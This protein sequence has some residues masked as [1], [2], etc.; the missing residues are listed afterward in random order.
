[1]KLKLIITFVFFLYSIS[2]FSN[3]NEAPEITNYFSENGQFML[4]VYPSHIPENYYK[5]KN[6]KPKKKQE[7]APEDTCIT[8]CHAILYKIA[9]ADTLKIWEKNLINQIAPVSVIVANDGQSVVT[10]DNWYSS[11]YG[12]NVMVIY[13]QKGELFKRY[14]LEDFSPFPIN[15][16]KMEI[17][18]ILWRCGQKY[19]TNNEIEI[20]CKDLKGNIAHKKYNLETHEFELSQ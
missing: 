19:L 1:M 2:T 6:A 4:T 11:G 16:Y 20:C 18:S 8:L 13:N 3:T 7:F 17:S 15:N 12:I 10:F 5:W 14:S 9:G